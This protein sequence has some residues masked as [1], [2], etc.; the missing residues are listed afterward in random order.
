MGM[1]GELPT[2]LPAR[3]DRSGD[4]RLYQP[5]IHSS[6]IREL[7]KIGQQIHLPLTVIVD[8]A[9]EEYIKQINQQEQ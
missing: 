8:R 9:I 4:E 5:Q 1:G 6:R 2:N 3:I 7:Y